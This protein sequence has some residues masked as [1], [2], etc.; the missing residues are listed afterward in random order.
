MELLSSK[1]IIKNTNILGILGWPF[2]QQVF[3]DIVSEHNIVGENH[4]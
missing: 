2:I 1:K 4:I 3:D